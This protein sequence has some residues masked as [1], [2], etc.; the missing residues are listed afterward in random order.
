MEAS[1]APPR[2]VKS[3]PPTTT[4]RRSIRPRHITKLVGNT[5]FSSAPSYSAWPVSSPT[6]W[7]LTGSSSASIRSRTV[8]RPASCCLLTLSTPPIARAI[9]WRRRSSS[10][11]GSQLTATL[12]PGRRDHWTGCL[13]ARELRCLLAEEAEHA[14][15]GV[16]RERGL[17]E[18]LHLELQGVLD[19]LHPD[20]L[21]DRLLDQR[22]GQR[23]ARGQL[24]GLGRN[25]RLEV[26][27]RRRLVYQADAE[28]VLGVDAG[29]LQHHLQ[30]DAGVDQPRQPLGPTGAGDD[31]EVDLGLADGGPAVVDHDPVVARERQLAATSQRV[32]IDRGDHDLGRLLQAAAAPFDGADGAAKTLLPRPP[33]RAAA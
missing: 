11:S 20:A 8:S 23:S 6:S 28:G 15:D 30:R 32:A 18:R 31:P 17:D 9:S 12:W 13:L 33:V 5:D 25:A 27:G 21:V 10:S 16:L 14:D 22:L 3:S 19:F 4:G 1:A 24:L 2:S 7:K 26:L 29:P